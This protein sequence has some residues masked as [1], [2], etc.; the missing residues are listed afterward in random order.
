MKGTLK[1][2]EGNMKGTLREHEGN[3]KGTLNHGTSRSLRAEEQ[4]EQ[5]VWAFL[6]SVQLNLSCSST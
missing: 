3:M 4:R 6:A 1:E 2:H 5:E